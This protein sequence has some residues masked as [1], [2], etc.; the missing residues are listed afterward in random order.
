MS[1][2]LVVDADKRLRGTYVE[3]LEIAGYS[4]T[5]AASAQ[6]SIGAIEDRAPDLILLE[7]QL[8][9]HSGVEFLHELR[10]Y[11]EWQSIPV[12]LHTMVPWSDLKDFKQAFES[13]GIIDYA[14]KPE[15]SLKQL[16]A[17]VDDALSAKV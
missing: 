3:V 10:S 11:P 1:H 5:P 15:T 8:Q 6:A 13:L 17:L 2:I 9:A 16:V 4:V 12:V 7:L 14:Y